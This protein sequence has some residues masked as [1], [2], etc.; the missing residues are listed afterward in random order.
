MHSRL[1]YLRRGRLMLL[2]AASHRLVGAALIP[3]HALRMRGI[4]A[5]GGRPPHGLRAAVRSSSSSGGGIGDDSAPR[6]VDYEDESEIPAGFFETGSVDATDDPFGPSQSHPSKHLPSSPPASLEAALEM[7]RGACSGCGARFQCEDETAPG[8]VPEH[9]LDGRQ[10]DAAANS[11]SKGAPVC[12]RCHGLRY[13]N[14]LPT[15]TLRVG[16]GEGAAAHAELQPEY[17]VSLLEDISRRRCVVVAIVDLFDFHG[18]LIP[19]L[20]RVVA[21]DASLI[22]VANKLDLLPANVDGKSVERWV[23]SEA[24][25]A[26][27]PR[28]HAVHLVSCKSGVGMPKLLSEMRDLMSRRRLDAY[29]VGAANA[30]KSSFINHVLRS[31]KAGRSVTTSHLPGTTLDFVRVSVL[32]GQQSLY[33]TPGLILPNQLTNALNTDELS[34]VVPKKRAQHVT[35]RVSEGKSVLLGGVARVHMRAGRPFLLTFYLANAVR[36]H[37]TSTAKIE[38][39]LRKHTGGILAPPASYERLEELGEFDETIF[40]LEG[41]GWDEAA[42]D[43]VL[44]GLGWV[45]VTGC[46]PCT[47][48]VSL[49][50]PC[51][52]MRR[53]PLIPSEGKQGRKKSYV[54]FTGTKLRDGRGNTKR[55][56]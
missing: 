13:Q 31:V 23:R 25:R 5:N 28:A 55:V 46:G 19:Q 48:G 39:V 35:L 56:R 16:G 42:C 49:P 50:S 26:G 9:V 37:P 54:K 51:G 34:Q 33:D 30:G 41:R 12:Q 15:E 22:L 21:E 44:P 24:K 20:P 8:F 53:E 3:H 14:R 2:C 43:L 29:V 18:S 47:I 27:L 10:A 38:E 1:S 4:S 17:F 36:I 45:S 32:A 52:A 11:A 7:P 40:D 6:F